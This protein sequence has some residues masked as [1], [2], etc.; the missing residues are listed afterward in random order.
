ME[1]DGQRLVPS[2]PARLK[3]DGPAVI[4]E[5]Q[6][7]QQE[8]RDLAAKLNRAHHW[9]NFYIGDL[10]ILAEN[11][12]GEEQMLQL[13]AEC[14]P[15]VDD[16]RLLLYR[17]VAQQFP[18]HR[19][20]WN[21]SWYH[22][23]TVCTNGIGEQ[24]QNGLLEVSEQSELSS[25]DHYQNVKA[26]KQEKGE[27]NVYPWDLSETLSQINGFGEKLIERYPREHRDV[28]KNSLHSI[29]ERFIWE[30]DDERHSQPALCETGD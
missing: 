12:F 13:V 10:I 24:E 28:V 17:R 11:L 8:W 16:K 4:A 25:R 9:L 3:V 26:V 29:W 27:Y 1:H 7:T 19:R 22:Y 30:T 14:L 18:P 5:G 6:F 2:L 20:V 15:S 21:L 23:R